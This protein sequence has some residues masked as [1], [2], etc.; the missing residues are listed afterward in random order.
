MKARGRATGVARGARAGGPHG[1]H[2]HPKWSS[3]PLRLPSHEQKGASRRRS[4]TKTSQRQNRYGILGMRSMNKPALSHVS[5][6]P[7]GYYKPQSPYLRHSGSSST[8][9]S[10]GAESA[11]YRRREAVEDI[12]F[13]FD[14]PGGG[15][16]GE[17]SAVA[18]P[19]RSADVADAQ[20]TRHRG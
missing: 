6:S 11:L 13:G 2:L 1:N 16:D 19:P 8:G 5:A 20:S 7:P 4:G 14:F 12:T 3:V 10:V 17:Q 9:C 15:T 18:A